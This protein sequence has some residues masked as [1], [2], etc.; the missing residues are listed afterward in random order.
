MHRGRSLRD[1]DGA[2]DLRAFAGPLPNPI[3]IL[4]LPLGAAEDC[5]N[6]GN[7]TLCTTSELEDISTSLG[8]GM[9]PFAGEEFVMESLNGAGVR[10]ASIRFSKFSD[11]DGVRFPSQ[12]QIWNWDLESSTVI[13]SIT[14][15]IQELDVNPK[16]PNGTFVLPPNGQTLVDLDK[17]REGLGI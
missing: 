1:L 6:P 14:F 3:Q 5:I 4:L 15:T 8:L 9:T 10:E 7:Q 16:I 13:S 11:F 2:H 17:M 12:I